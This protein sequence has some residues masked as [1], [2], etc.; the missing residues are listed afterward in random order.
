MSRNLHGCRANQQNDRPLGRLRKP[1]SSKT[2][3]G[4]PISTA[5]N[6]SVDRA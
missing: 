2:S 6:R 3:V 4:R 1:K 5:V